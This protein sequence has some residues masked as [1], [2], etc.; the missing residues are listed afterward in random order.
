[1]SALAEAAVPS[2][3]GAREL[4]W[5]AIALGVLAAFIALPPIMLR[6]P[7][8]SLV[9]AAAAVAAGVF[10]VRDGEKRLGW[11]AIVVGVLAGVGAV[12]AT[13]T[14]ESSLDAVFVW[15]A[16]VAAMLRFATP[17]MFAALGGLLC[18]RSGVI[19]IGLEGMMLM[20][21]FFGIFGAD[22]TGSWLLGCLIGMASGGA[23]ALIHAVLSISFRADQVVSG[24]GDQLPRV[25][26][27]GLR[28]HRPLRRP[29]HAR[30]R[31]ARA[32]AVAAADRGHRLLR[33]GDRHARTCSP[34]SRCCSW[35]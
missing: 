1:M 13:Q 33:R 27:H 31:P 12:A 6:T 10:A 22:L 9:L 19:N 28:L 8:P 3:V 2:R 15:S 7:V 21:A 32:H 29:G 4:A 11:I 14:N 18:E 25:R 20:G 16:L 34:G 24:F 35:C 30:R 17:L 23:L 5:V 26:D